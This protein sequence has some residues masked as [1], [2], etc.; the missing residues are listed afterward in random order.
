MKHNAVLCTRLIC[1]QNTLAYGGNNTPAGARRSS[2]EEGFFD[3]KDSE[4]GEYILEM[5]QKGF[6]IFSEYGLDFCK[7]H[8]LDDAVSRVRY[9]MI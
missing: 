2:L 9:S 3:L 6:P 7:Q 5:I 4:V 1:G 8:V